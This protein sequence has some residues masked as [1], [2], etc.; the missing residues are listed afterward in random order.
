MTEWWH[1]RLRVSEEVL[2]PFPSI[3]AQLENGEGHREALNIIRGP[4]ER[5][6]LCVTSVEL[7]IQAALGRRRRQHREARDAEILHLAD[8]GHSRQAIADALRVSYWTVLSTL[9]R[10]GVSV[11]DARHDHLGAMG[12]VSAHGQR[13]GNGRDDLA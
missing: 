11:R 8:E 4:R 10:A 9:K 13:Q 2:R 1:E 6:A 5:E 12:A 7:G 3:P